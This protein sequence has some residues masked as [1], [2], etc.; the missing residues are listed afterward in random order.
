MIGR[1]QSLYRPSALFYAAADAHPNWERIERD[2]ETVG[3]RRLG[4]GPGPRTPGGLKNWF[5]ETHT[6]VARK[7]IAA[8]L[9]SSLHEGT[10]K[11]Q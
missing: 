8:S 10:S 4:P 3:V 5:M 7:I 9:E 11:I 2:G 1:A 6:E